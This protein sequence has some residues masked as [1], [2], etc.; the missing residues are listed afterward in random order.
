MRITQLLA[1]LSR[2]VSLRVKRRFEKWDL[3]NET[4]D[5]AERLLAWVKV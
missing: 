4:T 2:R 3:R 5:G 1:V